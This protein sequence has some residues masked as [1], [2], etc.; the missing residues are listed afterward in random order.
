MN[1]TEVRA[2]EQ[3]TEQQWHTLRLRSD[4]GTYTEVAHMSARVKP[5]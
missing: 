5:R 2:C 1:D 4:F 3:K